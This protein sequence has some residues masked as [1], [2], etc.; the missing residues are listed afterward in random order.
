MAM[1]PEWCKSLD[2]YKK[3]IYEMATTPSEKSFINIPILMDMRFVGGSEEIAGQIKA[4]LAKKLNQNPQI[5][6][7]MSS[8]SLS[9]ETPL[10]ML[11]GFVL[12]K[13]AQRRA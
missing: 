7:R 5:L 2:A 10:G 11:G 9:F 3:D 13:R 1:N 12:D 6:S 8:A 4:Y